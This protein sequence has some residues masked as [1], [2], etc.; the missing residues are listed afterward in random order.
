MIKR[1]IYLSL[2]LFILSL[3]LTCLY[4]FSPNEKGYKKFL[5]QSKKQKVEYK[6]PI[7][8]NCTK[9]DIW[10]TKGDQ[11]LKLHIE[12]K[13]SNLFLHINGN[14][15]QMIEEMRDI[16]IQ[17][18]D[19]M[20]GEKSARNF[21]AKHGTY[22]YNSKMFLTNDAFIE[23]FRKDNTSPFITGTANEVSIS[24]K[25]KQPRI[26]AKHFNAKIHQPN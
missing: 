5:S 19:F 21:H 7:Y 13:T 23:I 24:L 22:N 6:H 14:K 8:R 25:Q 3:G 9:K 2:S 18:Q 12:N 1:S 26:N 11:R 16:F 20:H 15:L 4:L 17:T 10:Y